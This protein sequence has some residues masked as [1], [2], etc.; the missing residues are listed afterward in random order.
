MEQEI[1]TSFEC[2]TLGIQI[3]TLVAVVVT[4]LIY[5]HQLQVMSKQLSAAQAANEAQYTL[6]IVE[7]L[8][9][10]DVRESRKIVREVLSGKDYAQWTADEKTHASRVAANYDMAAALLRSGY[11]SRDLIA[12]NWN[13]S[14]CHCHK[15][16][17][18]H[19]VAHRTAEHGNPKYWTNFDWLHDLAKA[20]NA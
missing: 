4:A 1:V 5:Y 2:W 16:L 12:S 20:G 14:I 7:L 6:R 3:A 8:Q 17:L 18:P 13:A 15:V 9:H 10:E 19:V 11:G